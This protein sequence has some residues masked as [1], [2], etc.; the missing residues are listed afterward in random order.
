MKFHPVA[1]ALVP[2]VIH[3]FS[4]VPKWHLAVSLFHKGPIEGNIELG[5]PRM[6]HPTV[7][8][9]ITAPGRDPQHVPLAPRA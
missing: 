3:S 6:G 4:Q 5:S 7:T 8:S 1:L 2:K 9:W